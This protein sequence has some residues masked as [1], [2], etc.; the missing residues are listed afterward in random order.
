MHARV[1]RIWIA[2]G[3]I[4]GLI[5]L[6]PARSKTRS[7]V[8]THEPVTRGF[9]FI[10]WIPG[11]TVDTTAPWPP[12]RRPSAAETQ[13]WYDELER[14]LSGPRPIRTLGRYRH[15]SSNLPCAIDTGRMLGEVLFVVLI[16]SLATAWTLNRQ[17]PRPKPN[18]K[19]GTH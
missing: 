13:K 3:I 8:L 17:D 16:A 14:R 19:S 15:R 6:F 5:G 2:A 7:D 9:L 1:R 4:V 18:D 12:G 11:G 10:N